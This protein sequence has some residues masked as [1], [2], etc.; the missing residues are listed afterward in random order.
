[1][2]GKDLFQYILG[3]LIV[4]GFF[5]LLYLLVNAEVPE[6]NQGLLNLVV[7]ALIGSFATVV[8]YFYGSS[9]G[10]AEKT[11]LLQKK[12]GDTL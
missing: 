9:K 10:S 1:M 11:D 6:K 5:I 4:I 8:S 7:G 12:A 2:K 3:G